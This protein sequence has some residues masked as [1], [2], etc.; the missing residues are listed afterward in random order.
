MMGNA[1]RCRHNGAE[2]M[3]FKTCLLSG[4]SCFEV[5]VCKSGGGVCLDLA[6]SSGEPQWEERV[7][8][9]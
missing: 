9:H 3:D 5:D 1:S 2:T 8:T 7:T 6:N 4:W